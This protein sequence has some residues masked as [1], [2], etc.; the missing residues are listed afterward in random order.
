MASDKTQVLFPCTGN[1]CRSQKAEAWARA[2]GGN[3]LEVRSAGIE[4][5]GKNPRAI[6]MMAES[7]VDISGQESPRLTDEMLFWADCLVTVC[8]H[9]DEH[10]PVL[11][12]GVRK[13]HWPLENPVRAEGS[14]AEMF[15]VFRNSRD[16]IRRRV[17]ELLKSLQR[18]ISE[19][20]PS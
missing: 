15:Q 10:C 14:E 16:E 19:E 18:E 2:L 12:P 11:P 17:T 4:T 6:A 20:N 9:D 1:S 3:W 13:L 8:G 7:G 5:H